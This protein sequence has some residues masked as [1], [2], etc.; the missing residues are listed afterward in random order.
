MCLQSSTQFVVV[1]VVVLVIGA[2]GA[3]GVEEVVCVFFVLGE[4]GVVEEGAVEEGVWGVLASAA[5]GLFCQGCDVF[6]P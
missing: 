1:V 5:V 6:E 2:R 3:G 4:E